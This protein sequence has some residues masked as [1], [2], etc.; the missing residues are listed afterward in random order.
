MKLP[1]DVL[2]FWFA[3]PVRPFWFKKN[4]AFDAEIRQHFIKTYNAA[5]EGGLLEWKNT[6]TDMLAMIILFDQFP[7]HMFR[8]TERAYES[9]ALANCCAD[10]ALK[11][12]DDSYLTPDERIFLYMPLLHSEHMVDQER[13]VRFFR[14]L[15]NP[16]ALDYA[17]QH[18]EIV[19]QFG[20]FPHRNKL[21]GRKTTPQETEFLK[22]HTGF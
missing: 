4:P 21:L 5:Y 1:V 7:R 14:A 10:S 8:G 17:L 22:T 15:G 19:K 16:T 2:R 11:R 6:P 3:E 18:Y 13:S 20:R 12:G 9:D